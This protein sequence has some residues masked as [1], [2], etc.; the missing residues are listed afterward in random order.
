MKLYN[1][2]AN[3]LTDDVAGGG[4]RLLGHGLPQETQGVTDKYG[5]NEEV[6]SPFFSNSYLVVHY[7]CMYACCSCSIYCAVCIIMRVFLPVKCDDESIQ[8]IF[9]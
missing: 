8:E 6:V 1:K 5:S 9:L 7:V 3:P 4:D 2:A